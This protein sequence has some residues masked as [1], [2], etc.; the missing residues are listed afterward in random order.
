MDLEGQVTRQIKEGSQEKVAPELSRGLRN[1]LCSPGH[2][3]SVD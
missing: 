3:G 2:C 1:A